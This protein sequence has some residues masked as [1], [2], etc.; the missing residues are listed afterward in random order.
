MTVF[1]NL[2]FSLPHSL[3]HLQN[4]LQYLLERKRKLLV[5][6]SQKIVKISTA[7]GSSY[8]YI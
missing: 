2:I 7:I 6:E 3:T 8:I 5:L 4:Y 1:Q